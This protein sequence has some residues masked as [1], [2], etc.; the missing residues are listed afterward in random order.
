MESSWHE[1]L[2]A[3][4]M[5]AIDELVRGQEIAKRL[6][7]VMNRSTGADGYLSAG[8]LV[9]EIMNSFNSTLSIL[10]RG[11]FDEF[12]SQ[13]PA[14]TQM[15]SPC[16]DGRK[17]E[18]SG[19]SGRS[20]TATLKVK[21]RRGCYKR[22]K[23]SHSWM[24]EASALTDDGHA[25]RKYGQKLIL[26]AKY[27]RSYFRCTHK[28][29]QHC[30]ATKQVQRVQ[31]EPPLYRTTYH[32][33]HTCKNLLK[34]SHF[35]LDPI[36][37]HHKDSSIL[38]SFNNNK[39]NDENNTNHLTSKQDN[40]LF[41]SFQSIKQEPCKKE[42]SNL[43][44]MPISHDQTTHNNQAPSSDY[45]LSPEDH[46]HMSTFDHGDVISGVNS[47]CTTSSHSLDVDRIIGGSADFSSTL[48]EMKPNRQATVQKHLNLRLVKHL[49]SRTEQPSPSSLFSTTATAN[50]QYNSF[51]VSYLIRNCGFSLK[52]ALSASNYL[53]FD[54]PDKPDA[55]I[56][57]FKSHGASGPILAELSLPQSNIVWALG[58]RPGVFVASFERFKGIVEEIK[59]MGLNPWEL[60]FVKAVISMNRISKA[61]WE[62]KV[63]VHTKWG[64]T[65]EE[66]LAAFKKFTNCMNISEDK[67]MATTDF[68][69]NKLGCQSS[70]I[71]KHPVLLGLSLNKRVIPTASVIQFL[72]SE[73]LLKNDY[74]Y[75]PTVFTG[76]EEHFLPKY[77][78]CYD[79][80]PQL[81]E[82][83]VL[84][85]TFQCVNVVMDVLPGDQPQSKNGH[86]SYDH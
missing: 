16:W 19:E 83:M 77:V 78:N 59:E 22:R 47:S 8:D 31:E 58:S 17:S 57:L 62:K 1:N 23:N 56:N 81:L 51:T 21:D 42:E 2:P 63:D 25:W 71:A 70:V 46:D 50:L 48:V 68:F 40:L 34:A 52:S 6:K 4:R 39:N 13:I 18:D 30:Q 3:T 82:L 64:W 28:F 69:V 32:G 44:D 55:L 76:T 27:P 41:P 43:I 14:N 66:I 54:G 45:L 61:T 80:A 72:I 38:L 26:N 5:K 9:M 24:N 73:G 60:C 86:S 75:T 74:S 11:E 15:G 33:H 67:I 7:L 12:V 10:K 53:H 36:D 65:V 35:V 20:T 85:S 79:K 84:S 37:Q 29:D 49:V